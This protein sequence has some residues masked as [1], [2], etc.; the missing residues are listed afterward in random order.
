MAELALQGIRVVNT[1][2]IHQAQALT[3]RLE[4]HGAE[5]LAYPAITIEPIRDNSALDESLRA[6][7]D[8][9]FDWLVLTSSN[10]VHVLL[11]RMAELGLEPEALGELKVAAI[12]SSTAASINS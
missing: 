6:A 12:G 10:T 5:V 4:A 2:A 9:A 1:R 3:D 7:V 11:D 8:G